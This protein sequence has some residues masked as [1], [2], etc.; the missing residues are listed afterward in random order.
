[1]TGYKVFAGN[2]EIGS[3]ELGLDDGMNVWSGEFMPNK[4]CDAYATIFKKWAVAVDQRADDSV[5]NPLRAE[6]KKLKLRVQDEQGKLISEVVFI[7]D[8]RP[9]VD[10]CDIEA[11][12][13][14]YSYPA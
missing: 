8:F 10:A 2:V 9:D 13:I 3:A 7:S 12:G 6:M 1:M 14:G 11:Y 5:L 4:Q